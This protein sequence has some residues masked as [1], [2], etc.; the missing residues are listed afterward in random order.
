L[1]ARFLQKILLFATYVSH[2][3]NKYQQNSDMSYSITVYPQ[4]FF[5]KTQDLDLDFYAVCDFLEKEANLIDFSQEQ[6]LN[7]E[8]HLLYRKYKKESIS[9]RKTEYTHSK[10]SSVSAS[11]YK[12]G[13]FFNA[14]GED[15]IFEISMTSG[16]FI[17][18][19]GLKGN[20]A[21]FDPQNKGW[22]I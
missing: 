3:F 19:Y 5:Q 18:S 6:I 16:D 15:G 1:P 9:E 22:Q 8:E 13:L 21:V 4:A 2:E 20:F 10:L 17:S 12:N 7:I 11:L 14:R